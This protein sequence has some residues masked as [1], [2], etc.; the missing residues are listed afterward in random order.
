MLNVFGPRPREKLPSLPEDAMS[1][2][3]AHLSIFMHDLQLGSGDALNDA[4]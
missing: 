4:E 2:L 1:E 3:Q